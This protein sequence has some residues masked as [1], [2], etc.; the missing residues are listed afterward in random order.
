MQPAGY[1]KRERRTYANFTIVSVL[2]YF[3][4]AHA[5]KSV[6]CQAVS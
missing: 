3:T 2:P 5:L 6:H 1:Q 4:I